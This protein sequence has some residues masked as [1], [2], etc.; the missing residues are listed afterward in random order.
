[1]GYRLFL[2]LALLGYFNSHV[3][4]VL[5]NFSIRLL[6]GQNKQ[7]DKISLY[8]YKP[9]NPQNNRATDNDKLFGLSQC[10]F[11]KTDTSCTLLMSSA[12]GS[13]SYTYSKYFEVSSKYL[14]CSCKT[15]R[16]CH[17]N[18]ST[19]ILNFLDSL[20]CPVSDL[21]SRHPNQWCLPARRR[22]VSHV[23]TLH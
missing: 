12:D 15:Q 7:I 1:M 6:D 21:Q 10:E 17:N 3:D 23:H 19:W 9:N 4:W 8:N 20:S 11:S 13:Y 16:E 18:T 2:L 14:M 22:C 5:N